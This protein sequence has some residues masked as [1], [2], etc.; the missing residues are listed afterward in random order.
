MIC[1]MQC[2]LPVWGKLSGVSA[3]GKVFLRAPSETKILLYDEFFT[4][5]K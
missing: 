3:G 5:T 2:A 4:V 1:P